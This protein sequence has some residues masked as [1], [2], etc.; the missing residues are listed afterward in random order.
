MST[1]NGAPTWIDLGTNDLAGAKQFYTDLFGWTYQ[2]T[3]EEFGHYNIILSE[4]APVGGL[5]DMTA[6]PETADQPP[7][8]GVYLKVADIAATTELVRTHGGQVLF[9]PMPVGDMGSMAIYLDATGAM[10]GAWQDGTFSGTEFTLQPGSPVW[11]EIMSTDFDASV[12]F[13]QQV[14]GWELS[15]M[16][17]DGDDNFRYSTFGAGNDAVA[18]ICDAS[19]FLPAGTTSYWRYYLGVVNADETA[20][21]FRAKGGQVLDGPADSPFGRFATVADP[22]GAQFQINQDPSA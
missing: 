12:D 16:P 2:D 6:N 15:A 7:A 14:F 22:Q 5:M 9:E 11:F 8:W 20:A 1:R 19:G 10:V 3:G 17:S 13:Y 21:Q 4:G 18:G